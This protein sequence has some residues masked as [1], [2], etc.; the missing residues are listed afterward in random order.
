MADTELSPTKL[1]STPAAP[2]ASAFAET[3]VGIDPTPPGSGGLPGSGRVAPLAA[4]VKLG[5]FRI[6]NHLGRGG[7]GDVYRAHDESLDR[8]VALKTVSPSLLAD[9]E[10]V[11][12]FRAEA[13]SAA[14]IQHPHVVQV[15]SAGEAEGVLFFAM[16]L[17]EGRS[18]GD[19]LRAKGPFPW[20]EA[21]RIGAQVARALESAHAHGVIHRD[22][23]PE[24]ILLAPDG[25]AKV[26]DFG[27]AKRVS[28][29]GLTASGVIVGTPRYMSPEQAQGEPLDE[30]SDMYS[31]GAT[32]FHLLAG[33]PVFDGSSPMKVCLRHIQETPPDIGKVVPGLPVE[34][35]SCITRLLAKRRE[36]RPASYAVLA[37]ELEAVARL[38]AETVKI[39]STGKGTA[40]PP[41]VA[42]LARPAPPAGLPP[43][44]AP[45]APASASAS[46]VASATAGSATAAAIPFLSVQK[47]AD[48]GV[49]VDVTCPVSPTTR[50]SRQ[51][52]EARAAAPTASRGRRLVADLVDGGHLWLT[53]A[54]FSLVP[55][56]TTAW[57][58]EAPTIAS[59]AVALAAIHYLTKHGG[60]F[61]ER[62]MDVRL[63]ARS[64]GIPPHSCVNLGWVLSKGFPLVVGAVLCGVGG[65]S[66]LL[67]YADRRVPEACGLMAA[68]ALVEWG[69]IL[70][71]G[72]SFRDRVFK[73]RVIDARG[74]APEDDWI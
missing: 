2:L 63:V 19:L 7:M 56:G 65:L 10:F 20:P 14:R 28:E 49:S 43:P 24:N 53:Y 74:L 45:S 30:R 58:L 60:T 3:K 57:A 15:F 64:G 18:L 17:V 54:A 69:L 23:K 27:L 34:L 4:G 37:N 31:L 36:D 42:G 26:A 40:V 73:A 59:L 8:D 71:T 47:R 50:L 16:E 13:K 6:V 11:E 44:P 52:I 55:F 51:F 5:T 61:G 48:G 9:A 21:A 29:A 41:E 68:V 35:S 46:S 39:P 25:S 72:T 62:F 33:Q 12:R 1:V 22:V 66:P 70:A 67:S 38:M 32:L